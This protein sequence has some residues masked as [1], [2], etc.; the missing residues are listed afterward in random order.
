L[1]YESEGDG[2]CDVVGDCWAVAGVPAAAV[3][4]GFF[5]SAFLTSLRSIGLPSSSVI[6]NTFFSLGASI[7]FTSISDLIAPLPAPRCGGKGAVDNGNAGDVTPAATV[8]VDGID[9]RLGGLNSAAPTRSP[10]PPTDARDDGRFDD[11][12]DTV[13]GGN[14]LGC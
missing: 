2:A 4:A 5:G 10:L 3:V 6:S 13:D 14:G 11:A 8:D 9:A 1:T 12:L 7:S